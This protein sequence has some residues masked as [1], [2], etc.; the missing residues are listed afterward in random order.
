MR[1]ILLLTRPLPQSRRLASQARETCPAHETVI[2]PLSEVVGLP[3]D[4]GVFDGARGL[5]LTSANA[6]RFLPPLPP[7]P[8]WCV[9]PATAKAAQ[10]AG[11]A[12]RDGGGDAAALIEVLTRDAPEGALVH[13]HG[14]HLARD[15]VA[16]LPQL[17]LRGVAVYDARACDFPPGLVERLAGRRVVV[18]LFSPRAA[19]RFANQTGIDDLAELT[20]VAISA[21]CAAA[22]PESLRARAVIAD[23][24]DGAAMLRAIK[25]ALSQTGPAG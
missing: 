4:A 15:L 25:E 20:P 19:K 5:V 14:V 16:A 12:P 1:P 24:P 10:D 18:A 9:G 11:F 2:A 7:L 8:A 22:L 17:S 6:V 3:F 23:E 21:A 13:A